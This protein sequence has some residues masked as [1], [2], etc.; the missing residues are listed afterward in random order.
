M[1]DIALTEKQIQEV[2][3]CYTDPL[4][5]IENYLWI[6]LKETQEV[7]SFIPYEYQ[8]KIAKLLIEGK[9]GLILK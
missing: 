7:V 3:K 9:N 2:Y 4:Y 1:Q 6:E 5:F 8:K